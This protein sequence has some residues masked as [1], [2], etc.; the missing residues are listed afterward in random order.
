MTDRH[1]DDTCLFSCT[2]AS[3]DQTMLASAAI[4]RAADAWCQAQ[5]LRPRR[6]RLE[7]VARVG[8]LRNGDLVAALADHGLCVERARALAPRIARK[9]ADEALRALDPDTWLTFNDAHGVPATERRVL[10]QLATLA[11]EVA[12]DLQMPMP[13]P[14]ARVTVEPLDRCPEGPWPGL[15]ATH[16]PWLATPG[17]HSCGL[18][19]EV[20]DRLVANRPGVRAWP[21]ASRADESTIT[22]RTPEGRPLILVPFVV[23][24]RATHA[25]LEATILPDAALPGLVHLPSARECV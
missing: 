25:E 22:V 18:L 10:L 15:L 9:L 4:A 16:D 7:L 1:D 6:P 13:V 24:D 8:T 12:A 5:G 11:I 14:H 3:R 17:L 2:N 21:P 23:T 19:A 20:R